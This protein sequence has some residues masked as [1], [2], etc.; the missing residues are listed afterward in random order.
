MKQVIEIKKVSEIHQ[1]GALPKPKHPLISVIYNRDLKTVSSIQ[2]VKIIN[3]LYSIFFKSSN[4][5]SPFSYGRS[6]YDFEEGTLVFTA[7][8]Q[9]MAFENDRKDPESI[10][11]NGWSLV[12]H[13]D[14]FRKS[15]LSDK[16]NTYSFFQYDSSE[17]LHVS[18]QEKT[19]LED[20]LEKIVQEYS[21]M[22][23]RHRQHKIVANVE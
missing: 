16:I 18:E 7:P 23:D 14:I 10:D 22:L 13:P 1:I 8:G 6:S 17:A 21:Q 20:L 2:G 3:Q 11:P 15:N 5:C 12:F 4:I 19:S 9:I